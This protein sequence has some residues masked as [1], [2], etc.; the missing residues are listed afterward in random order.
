MKKYICSDGNIIRDGYC[1]GAIVRDYKDPYTGC[2][3]MPFIELYA[4]RTI[5]GEFVLQ[6][7]TMDYPELYKQ[8]PIL[9]IDKVDL[10][11]IFAIDLIAFKKKLKRGSMRY[12]DRDGIPIL[13]GM[14]IC[15]ENGGNPIVEIEG[16]LFLDV[17]HRYISLDKINVKKCESTAY[18]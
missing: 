15:D 3:E 17:A 5:N 16:E 13:A 2:I 4:A 10:K 18:H 9:P 12:K 14:C 6:C 8:Y 7:V 11:K 1:Y